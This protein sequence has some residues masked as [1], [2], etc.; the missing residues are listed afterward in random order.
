M[1]DKI[2]EDSLMKYLVTSKYAPDN[3]NDIISDLCNII[4]KSSEQNELLNKLNEQ[5]KSQIELLQ[6]NNRLLI[7]EKKHNE[8]I[9][10][11]EKVNGNI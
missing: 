4:N 5:Q 7:L 2:K 11:K 10:N 9:K 6:F 3:V 1:T 8:L